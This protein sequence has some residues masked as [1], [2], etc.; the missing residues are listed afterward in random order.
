VREF[1]YSVKGLGEGF[2]EIEGGGDNLRYLTKRRQLA[3]TAFQ[4]M[5]SG[6]QNIENEMR[7]E[8][9][10]NAADEGEDD[11]S[12]EKGQIGRQLEIRSVT[13]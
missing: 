13:K 12:E 2:W 6:N 1:Q 5:L 4:F 8:K 11:V 10:R 9:G 7:K 3:L